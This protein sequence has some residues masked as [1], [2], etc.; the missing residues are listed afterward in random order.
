M[1]RQTVAK[2]NDNSSTKSQLG[3]APCWLCYFWCRRRDSNSH[4]FRHYP[5]KIACL[6][7]SPRRLKTNI[8][9]CFSPFVQRTLRYN[10]VKT[11]LKIANSIPDHF[12]IWLACPAA[13]AGAFVAGACCA[14]ASLFGTAFGAAGALPAGAA[15]VAGAW[16]GAAGSLSITPLFA[17]ACLCPTKAS[18]SV[19]AKKIAAARPVDFDKKLE[20]PV[21]PKRLPDAPEPNAAPM[22]APLPC[23]ISTRPMIAKA[24][25]T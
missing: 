7:I 25:N 14:G 12:G 9:T 10:K 22:S 24:D 16:A 13:P 23:C 17:G 4:S 3:H 8:L 5:L 20:E 1:I 2:S 21:A 15:G 6:P 18:A 11:K 19:A